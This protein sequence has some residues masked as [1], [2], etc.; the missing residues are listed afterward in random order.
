M[1]CAGDNVKFCITSHFR[2]V[3]ILAYFGSLQIIAKINSAL[4]SAMCLKN[5]TAKDSLEKT[6]RHH[7]NKTANFIS[8][9]YF[10]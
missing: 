4:M 5:Y 7:E 9:T 2:G 10:A 6:F 8:Y 1:F 3:L